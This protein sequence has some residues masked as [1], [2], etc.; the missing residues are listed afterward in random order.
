MKALST[1][2]GTTSVLIEPCRKNSISSCDHVGTW[3]R[4]KPG[5]SWAEAVESA[6]AK[7]ALTNKAGNGVLIRRMMLRY[8]PLENQETCSAN[9]VLPLQAQ[10]FGGYSPAATS[11]RMLATTWAL[12]SLYVMP[13]HEAGVLRTFTRAAPNATSSFTVVGM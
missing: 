2:S 10:S 6:N 7:I 4:S 11:L 13:N 3:A 8:C 12:S 1:H 5:R 9:V